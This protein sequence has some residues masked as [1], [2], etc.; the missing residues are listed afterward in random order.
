MRISQ[1]TQ[2]RGRFVKLI[3]TLTIS[4]VKLDLLQFIFGS[5]RGRNGENFG[6][7]E[8]LFGVVRGSLHNYVM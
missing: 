4:G 3:V 2:R 1:K 8:R 7:E 6:R 5:P